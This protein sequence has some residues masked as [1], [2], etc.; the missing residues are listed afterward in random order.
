M[1][2]V[3]V[4]IVGGGPVGGA[5]ASKLLAR[6]GLSVML[7]EARDKPVQDPRALAL[8][9]ASAQALQV[10]ALWPDAS[11][12]TPITGVHVSQQGYFGRTCL[13]AGDVDWPQL[14][15]V[16]PYGELSR[17]VDSRLTELAEQGLGYLTGCRVSSLQLTEGYASVEIT[18]S[19]A[20]VRMVTASLVVL[21][22][23]GQLLASLPGATVQA[24]SYE[25]VALLTEVTTSAPQ[26]GMAFERFAADG[27]LAFLPKG[28]GYAVVWTQPLARQQELASLTE[29]ELIAALQSRIGNRLGRITGA[30]VPVIYPLTLKVNR[31]VA[32]PRCVLIGNA[33]QTLHPVAGQG[34]N[35]GLRDALTLAQLLETCPSLAL[36]CSGLLQ[37]Y[38]RLRQRDAA[39]VTHFTDGLIH[40]FGVR[41]SLLGHAR[42]AGLW[43]LDSLAGLRHGFTRQMVEGV[44]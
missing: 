34:F 30:T 29:S 43:A 31:P 21:A 37:Q 1:Q 12:T 40:L 39:A 19:N 36:E 13:K 41:H 42:G 44:R 22:E 5:L 24:R 9:Q 17:R 8:S 11:V 28:D 33:A 32:G 18:A 3:D 16:V 14:G 2:H 20:E 4:L 15:F 7:V 27:P 23:G 6:T 10:L 38:S 26:S 35:L 25:Q